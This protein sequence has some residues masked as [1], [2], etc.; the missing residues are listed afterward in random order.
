[1]CKDVDG[2]GPFDPETLV[3][4]ECVHQKG[5][6]EENETLRDVPGFKALNVLAG[7]FGGYSREE[8]LGEENE[9]ACLAGGGDKVEAANCATMQAY[10]EFYEGD[11]A[12][13]E[14]CLPA[15]RHACC[16]APAAPAQA[17]C[18]ILRSIV[19]TARRLSRAGA[20]KVRRNNGGG[21]PYVRQMGMGHCPLGAA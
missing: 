1:M 16:G 10:Q 2:E 21:A 3:S 11:R 6:G 20:P 17:P 18:G 14:Q 13:L 12:E 19:D 8:L 5:N 7:S 9:A 4:V 15:L